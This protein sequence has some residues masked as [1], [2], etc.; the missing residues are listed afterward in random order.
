MSFFSNLIRKL[1]REERPLFAQIIF[2]VVA[3]GAMFVLSYTFASGIVRGHLVR[4]T[5][6]MLAFWQMQIKSDLHAPR[7]TLLGFSETVRIMVLRNYNGEHLQRHVV[8]ISEAM[9]SQSKPMPSFRGIYGYFENI[10]GQPIFVD[11]II[12]KGESIF[13]EDYDPTQRIW[14]K[15]AL[16]EEGDTVIETP[17]FIDAITG[18]V[19]F[20]FVRN[21]FDDNGER[22]GVVGMNMQVSD[23]GDYVV[24]MALAQGS[25]GMLMAQD[26][27]VLA[28][29]NPDFI[30]L[31]MRDLG[32]SV[33]NLADYLVDGVDIS[34]RDGLLSYVGEPAITFFRRLPNGWYLGIVTPKEPY[35]RSVTEMAMVLG[36]L[37]V[38]LAAVLILVLIRID[39]A[40][41]KSDM[42]SKH[43]SAFLANMSHE[44]RT[45]M[46]A[47]IGM[48]NIG[49]K[50]RGDERKDY[51]FAKIEDASN[52]LL[53][54]INDI[55][56]MSKIEANKLELSTAEFDFERMLQRVVNVIN[57]RISEKRQDLS[58]R[59]D[60][61]IPKMLIGD[62]Q[63]LAQVITNLLSNAT[64][65][66]PERGVIRLETRFM[67]EEEDG[68]YCKI[69]FRVIDNG[70]GLSKDQQ[71]N[72][73]RSFHQAEASTARRF[74]GTGLGLSISKSI[75]EMM[76]GEIWVES[77]L[78]KGATFIFTVRM[79]SGQSKSRETLCNSVNWGNVKILA[80]DDDASVLLYLQETLRSFGVSCDVASCAD[81]ALS[82]VA[83][84]GAYNIY[85][86]DWRMPQIDGI[87][88]AEK[89]KT[90]GYVHP[91]KSVVI[92][93]SSAELCAI[94]EAAQ[95]AGVNK[96]LSKPLFPSA[97]MDVLNEFL[98]IESQL[99]TTQKA[100]S[101]D[102]YFKNYRVLLAEDVKVNCE[103]VLALFEPTQLKIDCAENG[104]E[105]IEKFVA[106]PD[107][108]DLI[109]MDVQMP[110]MDGYEAT[111]RIRA[112]DGIPKAKT[113]PI[114]AMTAN[115]FKEDIERC[116]ESGMND[117]I[118]KP[119]DFDE[120]FEKLRKYLPTKG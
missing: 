111:K 49:K 54:V 33:A 98:D 9:Y 90:Q 39:L 42:E 28:H 78:G 30:G 105:V 24:N 52:H 83:A 108:Y 50:S 110:D 115:V 102:G 113:V 12:D 41:S 57:Y 84:K 53:G 86:L 101:I 96:F 71:T 31:N 77:D 27:T 117:H 29:P 100:T 17:H 2:T 119:L 4:N 13:P 118:G 93:I 14:Y 73:F 55:L 36:F 89:L 56:D 74:G 8:Y 46:N 22:I 40:R 62:D 82:I 45:P 72:L 6:N 80:V 19:V 5:E 37:G 85:F 16:E 43:K 76:D 20:A 103:I 112:M 107:S 95:K 99:K 63:R 44:I 116:L 38:A 81:E 32:T 91:E 65:F 18:D 3:F 92:M 48:T 1:S 26:L 51:C 75:V 109:F 120:A 88:L 106:S 58:V 61:A 68:N 64:K 23:I 15:W 25:Y 35:Y 87:K 21:I 11:G 34:E 69:Q 97:I 114:V 67:G 60:K 104:F 59:I 79:K 66:T 7:T 70:I 47:I 94:E 10:K